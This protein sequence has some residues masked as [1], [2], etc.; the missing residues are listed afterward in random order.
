MPVNVIGAVA[1]L[2][3][4]IGGKYK[5]EVINKCGEDEVIWYVKK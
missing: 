1:P 4:E 2:G 3:N 5:A